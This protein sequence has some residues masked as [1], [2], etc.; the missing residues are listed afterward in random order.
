MSDKRWA[1][2]VVEQSTG[3]EIHRVWCSSE[4]KAERV[5][6]GMLMQM[7]VDYTTRIEQLTPEKGGE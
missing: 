7:S 5:E 6:N 1:V 4:R 2:V 3:E